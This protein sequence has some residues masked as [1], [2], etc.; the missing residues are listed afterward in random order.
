MNHFTVSPLPAKADEIRPKRLPFQ[1]MLSAGRAAGQRCL[2]HMRRAEADARGRPAIL[3]APVR[4][5][6]LQGN[7]S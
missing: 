7:E 4:V 3:L 5:S 2:P 6:L 1:A